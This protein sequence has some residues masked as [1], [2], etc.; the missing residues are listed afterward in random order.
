MTAAQLSLDG[1]VFPALPSSPRRRHWKQKPRWEQ[2]QLLVGGTPL[3]LWLPTLAPVIPLRPRRLKAAEDPTLPRREVDWKPPLEQRALFAEWEKRLAAEGMPAELSGD[4]LARIS[5]EQMDY[6]A[7]PGGGV[8]PT[9]A[10]RDRDS[11]GNR[12]EHGTSRGAWWHAE[13]E[14]DVDGAEHWQRMAD[15]VREFV[16]SAIE[17]AVAGVEG[18]L[19]TA[20]QAS[21]LRRWFDGM[22][23]TEIA[24]L[25]GHSKVT[26]HHKLHRAIARVA[27]ALRA[28][29]MGQG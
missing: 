9:L 5:E 2:L 28:A 11:E 4:G 8:R 18:A 24:R 21:V 26:V 20:P 12:L 22:A 27:E 23:Q 29:G 7:Q 1:F 13:V 17:A 14:P 25:E 15:E 3:L 16:D 6:L 19:L 10:R